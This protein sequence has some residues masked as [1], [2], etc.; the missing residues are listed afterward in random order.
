[1]KTYRKRYT[2]PMIA[3]PNRNAT[4]LDIFASSAPELA[5]AGRGIFLTPAHRAATIL[6]AESSRRKG[7]AG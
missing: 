6:V 3:G 5:I 1:M 4:A 2:H 7:Q